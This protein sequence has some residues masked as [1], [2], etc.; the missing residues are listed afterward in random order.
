MRGPASILPA[1][2]A[3]DFI[4]KCFNMLITHGY[5]VFRPFSPTQS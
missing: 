3:F 5:P 2:L 1:D 4:V